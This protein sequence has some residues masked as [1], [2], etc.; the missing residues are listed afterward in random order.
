MGAAEAIIATLVSSGSA[1]ALAGVISTWLKTRR[2]QPVRL[3]I[4]LQDG[5]ELTI[6]SNNATAKEIEEF[7]ASVVEAEDGQEDTDPQAGA[8]AP[9]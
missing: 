8:D 2:K 5:T 4:R 7:I 3:T 9:A 6:N 1:A